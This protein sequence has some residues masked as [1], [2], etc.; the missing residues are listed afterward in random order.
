[1]RA[2]AA[3]RAEMPVAETGP[4]RGRRALP[5]VV[6]E[7]LRR[8]GR[9]L[10]SAV[11]TE[12]ERILGHDL[13]DVRVHADS[14]A[15]QAAG[16]LGAAAFTA[17]GH[18]VF[19]QGRYQPETA[20]GLR[21]LAHELAHTVQQSAALAPGGLL[22]PAG[23]ASAQLEREATATAARAVAGD[24]VPP[25]LVSAATPLAHE[26]VALQPLAEAARAPMEVPDTP[27]ALL[28][29]AADVERALAFDRDDVFGRARSRLAELAPTTRQGVLAQL[30]V[31]LPDTQRALL[32]SMVAELAPEV[33]DPRAALAQAEA[34]SEE[35]VPPPDGARP[36]VA[37]LAEREPPGAGDAELQPDAAVTEEEGEEA[38]PEEGEPVLPEAP[39]ETEDPPVEAPQLEAHREPAGEGGEEGEP[40]PT[41]EE[42]AGADREGAPPAEGARPEVGDV[43]PAEPEEDA[44]DAE[45]A[46]EVESNALASVE[47]AEEE[48]EDSA[49][50]DAP[51]S[52]GT[53]PAIPATAASEESV[54]ED[55]GDEAVAEP[56]STEPPEA[57]PEDPA[58]FEDE[59]DEG[60]PADEFVDDA[61]PPPADEAAEA[62]PLGGGQP[63]SDA[64]AES[65]PG[66]LAAQEAEPGESDPDPDDAPADL[67]ATD[68]AEEAAAEEEVPPGDDDEG[69]PIEGPSEQDVSDLPDDDPDAALATV[70]SLPPAA[71][72][73]ALGGVSSAA[74]ASVDSRHEALAA[75]PPALQ[76]PSGAPSAAEQAAEAGEPPVTAGKPKL[77]RIPEPPTPPPVRPAP[78]PAPPDP[79]TQRIAA[80]QLPEGAHGDLSEE[81]KKALQASLRA[82]PVRDPGLRMTAGPA[83]ALS[84]EEGAD[85]ERAEA[86]RAELER[87]THATRV[88]G[89]RDVVRP[90]GETEL[91]PE[92]PPETLQAGVPPRATG[93]GPGGKRESAAH[94]EA[95]TTQE[96]A[97]SVVA[98]QERGAEL[99]GAVA[100]ARQD[101]AAERST[102]ESKLADERRDA[103]SDVDQIVRQNADSQ[104][105]ERRKARA[106]VHAERVAW[107]GEQRTLADATRKE[108]GDV[109]TKVAQDVTNR[110]AAAEKEAATHVETGN[111]EAEAARIAGEKKAAEERAK[112]EQEV[113]T[114][115]I[116]WLA[117][118][119][120]ELF[121][122]VKKAISDVF[123]AARAAVRDAIKKA[124]EFAAAAIDRARDLIV[125]AIKLA[126]EALVALGDRLLAG[127]PGLRDRFRKAV[128]ERVAKAEAAV[129]ALADE[130]KAGV[131]R[132]L[133]LLGAALDAVLGLLEKAL[134]FVVD[135]YR[136]AVEGA[137]KF[138]KAALEAFAVFAALVEDISADPLQ[139]IVNLGRG[140]KAG[141][142]KHLWTAF[143]KAIKRW[144]SEK[145][146]EVLGLGLTIWNV[147]KKGGIS[148]AKIGAMAWEAIKAAI[149]PTLIQI[150]IEKL[151]SLIIPAA[152][153]IMLIIEGLQAAWGTI[154]RVIEAFQRFFVF[155]KTV[156]SGRSGR[157]FAEALAAGAIALIDFV[158][159]W[160]LKRLRKPAGKIAAKIRELAKKLGRKLGKAVKRLGKKFKPRKG[161]KPK[162]KK[163]TPDQRAKAQR[164]VDKATEFLSRQL[165]RG[166]P[167]PILRAQMLYAAGVY[168]VRIRLRDRQQGAT[169]SIEASPGRKVLLRS[170]RTAKASNYPARVKDLLGYVLKYQERHHMLA[171][172]PLTFA[173]WWDALDI[174][175]HDPRYFLYLPPFLHQAG[176]HANYAKVDL[177]KA[178]AEQQR[179]YGATSKN[180]DNRLRA[181]VDAT[182]LRRRI[183]TPAALRPAAAAT[184]RATIRREVGAELTEMMSQFSRRV[185]Y[186]LQQ[187]RTTDKGRLSYAQRYAKALREIDRRLAKKAAQL[188][189]KGKELDTNEGRKIVDAVMKRAIKKLSAP[190]ERIRTRAVKIYRLVRKS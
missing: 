20:E 104:T 43:A 189:K 29:I 166:M 59:D 143:K 149:P 87:T 14:A 136:A 25:G 16:A 129:N 108:A 19:G 58:E 50:V 188:K 34:L 124:Q 11:R 181:W 22:E 123:E 140:A 118:K 66:T 144:F 95:L 121:D 190:A 8:D 158:A 131:Q 65:D 161:A 33:T 112:G 162:R 91:F 17:G 53:A 182:M 41:A 105:A 127:F 159:N 60:A 168:R 93:V 96:R 31:R 173:E 99:R 120:G 175:E 132:A 153:A 150:L 38:A 90:M 101:M 86:Q 80:P 141:V 78:L 70:S 117:A 81:G 48:A 51:G 74:S 184:L 114:G 18:I 77:A 63:E 103:E 30:G 82:L 128:Q 111:R 157:K 44:A 64:G 15:A 75:N 116:G 3:D 142:R 71:Q 23:P 13:G 37:D 178:S 26:H 72:R 165:V 76:R 10:D 45:P 42:G 2:H 94:A 12:M 98:M 61:V 4:R 54:P 56:A 148:L 47:E 109:T 89:H 39:V 160:L 69:T 147:L 113:D 106:D 183:K 186:D 115:P 49:E 133:D 126:G 138:A 6:E 110:R 67:G 84:L 46:G 176:L 155:L 170:G 185:G 130:L 73:K 5:R 179:L 27:E 21:L 177:K 145:V 100:D 134:L 57:G 156:K 102:H 139:W 24:R 35:S 92:V 135:A 169:L 52:A 68:A 7:E 171:K 36:A 151:V 97:E 28:E 62:G 164:R 152:G 163:Q 40:E 154:K 137:L 85:P 122:A 125:S 83:P 9:P 167:F 1:M 187:F 32:A 146:E 180:W 172:K 107:S 88:D 79:A 119:A 55:P 174:D